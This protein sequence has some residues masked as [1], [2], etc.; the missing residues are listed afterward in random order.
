MNPAAFLV[1]LLSIVALV[2][3]VVVATRGEKNVSTGEFDPSQ[4]N[5][6]DE[7]EKDEIETSD[8]SAKSGQPVAA[9]EFADLQSVETENKTDES[10]EDMSESEQQN[11]INNQDLSLPFEGINTFEPD[12]NQ[13]TDLYQDVNRYPW[14]EQDES[15]QLDYD[16]RTSPDT[17]SQKL[18]EAVKWLQEASTEAIHQQDKY[19]V[20]FESL[21]PFIEAPRAAGAERVGE[22]SWR[23]KSANI[24]RLIGERLLVMAFSLSCYGPVEMDPHREAFGNLLAR[25]WNADGLE[26]ALL[27]QGLGRLG[28]LTPTSTDSS[29]E[30]LIPRIPSAAPSQREPE[31]GRVD[32]ARYH[33]LILAVSTGPEYPFPRG[34]NQLSRLWHWEESKPPLATWPHLPAAL[35]ALWNYHWINDEQSEAVRDLAALLGSWWDAST[36]DPEFL[37][38][39][40]EVWEAI[41]MC[42]WAWAPEHSMV[43]EKVSER[44]EE[45]ANEN[46]R[47]DELTEGYLQWTEEYRENV[48]PPPE[49]F[50]GRR[51]PPLDWIRPL[52][53]DILADAAQP[54]FDF[55]ASWTQ[56]LG[57]I[58][59]PDL[60]NIERSHRP[61]TTQ[62]GF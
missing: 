34:D 30:I 59:P 13:W 7:W 14:P 31:L 1:L 46:A 2:I 40:P 45:L 16:D 20:F 18:K 43:W 52:P 9:G 37:D 35:Y 11:Q 33:A 3:V 49:S 62:G 23:E 50:S 39:N 17:P 22:T 53:S 6:K 8:S 42:C 44:F 28:L 54:S 4:F 26:A 60:E 48:E 24:S 25:Q 41:L 55:P 19:A 36:P 56:A 15:K 32:A 5:L 51:L 27:Y 12:A 10:R 21:F 58:T 47:L 38:E 29:Q 57:E 61:R